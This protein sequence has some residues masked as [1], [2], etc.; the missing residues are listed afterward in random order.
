MEDASFEMLATPTP[1]KKTLENATVEAYTTSDAELPTKIDPS[2]IIQTSQNNALLETAN[3]EGA[4]EEGES[5]RPT[6]GAKRSHQFETASARTRWRCR[7]G[8]KPS[9][10]SIGSRQNGRRSRTTNLKKPPRIY[11]HPVQQPRQSRRKAPEP[12]TK[13]INFSRQ[14]RKNNADLY[15]N[16]SQNA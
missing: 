8:T 12:Q 2:E 7:S 11:T 15:R 3:R 10:T 16:R 1:K 13:K 4:D 5:Y 9:G 14:R 6:P